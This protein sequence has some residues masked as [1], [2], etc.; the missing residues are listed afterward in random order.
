MFS[1]SDSLAGIRDRRRGD[2]IDGLIRGLHM[3]PPGTGVRSILLFGSWARG[4]FDGLS[5]IDLLVLTDGGTV[6]F[7]GVGLPFASRLDIVQVPATEHQRMAE[8]DHPFHARVAAEAV[9]LWPMMTAS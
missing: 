1:S 4:D 9:S 7:D 5:D 2:L 8:A 3:C 6:A